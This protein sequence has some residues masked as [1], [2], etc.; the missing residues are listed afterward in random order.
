[1]KGTPRADTTR[2][3]KYLTVHILF[4]YRTFVNSENID[5]TLYHWTHVTE[6]T[7][8]VGLSTGTDFQKTE[9]P[10][11]NFHRQKIDGKLQTT[12][13][14]STHRVKCN[15]RLNCALKAPIRD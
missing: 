3:V 11:Y 7:R 14:I 6:N 13:L 8:F 9:N 12:M 4:F 5:T 10:T 2:R 1:M 15:R